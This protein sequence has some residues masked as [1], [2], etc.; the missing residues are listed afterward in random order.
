[1]GPHPHTLMAPQPYHPDRK[2]RLTRMTNVCVRARVPVAVVCLWWPCVCGSLARELAQAVAPIRGL[3]EQ[4]QHVSA[5][6][7]QLEQ[8]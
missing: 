4:L 8:Q 6:K 5:E 7:R 3:E 2:P 1:M